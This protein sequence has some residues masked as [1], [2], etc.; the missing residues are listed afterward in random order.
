[1]SETRTMLERLRRH[2]I[3]PGAPLPGGVFLDEVTM[4]R[5]G[6]R[7]CDALYAGFT[8][9][10]G[11]LLVGHEIKVSR[12]DWL[13]ELAQ[14][15]KADAWADQCHAWYVVAPA[16][17][18]QDGELPPD[19]GLMVPGPS[20]TR[21]KVQK[22]ATVHTDRQPSWAAVLSILSRQDT[23]RAHA[24][25]QGRHKADRD[26][27]AAAD[28]WVAAE[29]ESRLRHQ[30]DAQKLRERIAEIEAALGAR[31]VDRTYG[32]RDDE[33]SLGD[34]RAIAV[35]ARAHGSLTRALSDVGRAYGGSRNQLSRL[36]DQLDG[37]LGDLRAVQG[38]STPAADVAR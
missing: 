22:R 33:V 14:V 4:G 10:S 21:M 5:Q 2:Y 19:W 38:P 23:L 8:T 34:L 12:S 29:V 37:A 36:L 24:I 11:R 9:A 17:I 26:A 35:A 31:I 7:R 27:Y 16:G 20:Q 32:D 18:V 3:K 30:P 6:G 25:E 28:A 1:M 15:G 13:H